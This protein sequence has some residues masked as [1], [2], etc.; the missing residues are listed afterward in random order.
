KARFL[1]PIGGSKKNTKQGE[2]VARKKNN[3][4]GSSG[5]VLDSGF[6]LLVD[7]TGIVHAQDSGLTDGNI[8]T[9]GA[10]GQVPKFNA[11]NIS[12]NDPSNTEPISVTKVVNGM[13]DDSSSYINKLSPTSLTKANLQKLDTNVKFN[14][15]PLV[16]YASDSDNVVMVVLNLNGPGYTKETIHVEYEW[17]TP[18]CSTCLI[19]GN[20]VDDCLKALKRV[21]NRVDKVKGG[22]FRDDD[23]DGFIEAIPK[24]APPAEKKKV[25]TT[26]NSSKKTRQTNASKSGNGTFSLSNSFKALNVDISVVKDVDSGDKTSMSGV[27]EERQSSTPLDKKINIVEQQLL[28][29]KCVFLDDEGKP[30]DKIDYTSD[31][32]S[33]DEIQPVDN[34]MA[35]FQASNPSG[36][37][38]DTSSNN[39]MK[40]MGML[41]TITT[42]M[43]MTYMKARKFLTKFYLQ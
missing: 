14:D 28:M 15:V 10:M 8:V 43:M 17:E 32:D 2:Q 23:D 31:H 22:S 33:E 36:V 16:A 24:T 34:E 6:S 12:C 25:S 26:S 19:F 18:R 42:H 5:S 3:T 7:V 41:I 4:N 11:V 40:L 35:S 30:V 13:N 21:V 27:H 39:G 37:G 29:E 38:Y 1:D 20:S 9:G